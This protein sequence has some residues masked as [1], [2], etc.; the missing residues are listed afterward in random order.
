MHSLDQLFNPNS[1]AVIGASTEEA[2]LGYQTM[3][4]LR[5]FKG[6]LYPINPKADSILAFK[7]YPNLKA[8]GRPVD[9]VILTI[10]A[11][12]CIEALKEAGEAGAGSALI[13][14]GGFAET[15]EAGD[16]IQQE[17]L[18]ICGTYGIRLLG[19][20]TAGFSNPGA[21]VIAAFNSWIGKVP[22]GPVGLIS[23]S[24]AMC[25]TLAALIHAQNLGLSLATG[26]GNGADVAAADAVDYLADDSNTKV[27]VI[28]LEG[29]RDGRRLY[30]VIRKTTD[31]KPVVVLTV[32]KSNIADFAV[33]HTGNLIGSFKIKRAA[34]KQAGAVI[35]DSSNEAID[36]VKIFSNVRLRPG[37]NPGVGLLTAQAGPGLIIADYLRSN[38]VILPEL[39]PETISKIRK[40]LPPISYIKNPVDTT[41]PGRSFI[42]VLKA[43]AEDPDIDIITVFALHE[44]PIIDPVAIFKSF[45]KIKQ[46]LIFG[47]AGLL[48]DILPTQKA[49]D[50]LNIPSFTSPDRTA[51]AIRALID[52]AKA[53][54]RKLNE[55]VADYKIKNFAKIK[56]SPNEAESKK[57][58]KN[59]GIPIPRTV[60]CRTYEEATKAFAGLK[61]PCVV[62]AVDP[63]ISHK[64][65]AGGV[66]LGI[67]TVKQLKD[68][69]KRI[70]KID[71]GNKKKYIVEETAKAGLEIII[72]GVND[73][74]FGPTVLLGLGG[75]TAEALGDVSMRLAPL[76]ITDA[77]EMINELKGRSLFDGWR[78]S[79]AVD[80]TK[81]AEALV[82]V[83]QLMM[84]H[85]EIRELDINPVRVYPKGLIAL[86]ALIVVK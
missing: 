11:Q 10:P 3:Y 44:P 23:Q 6:D 54:Y 26:I 12:S 78:G 29:V 48:E 53:S 43:V 9:L 20:N 49:L 34:L 25:F 52:D 73:P 30:N 40:E 5:N 7:A 85:T 76:T 33:S 27:I 72:G 41:R 45:G 35:A 21:G 79:P 37:T 66:I 22:A 70:D 16:K 14:S 18:S 80:K 55:K 71:T 81:V 47:T 4:A 57:I 65:E 15:G 39:Q 67:E 50:E 60:L 42:K 83:G 13:I 84:D 17:I 64:T 38:G 62:K 31:K 59:S 74:S 46:P 86:D 69:L 2:K 68:A 36:A 82:R 8:V 51:R 77:M 61:K 32:G 58:L 63:A 24:G 28:Y 19:P 1:I 75:I 56:K